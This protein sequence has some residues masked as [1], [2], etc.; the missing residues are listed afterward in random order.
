VEVTNLVDYRYVILRREARAMG[1]LLFDAH[2]TSIDKPEDISCWNCQSY[3]NDVCIGK[4]LDCHKVVECMVHK[5][6]HGSDG[7]RQAR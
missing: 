2:F 6:I 5:A 4:G 7:R 1:Q 3:L